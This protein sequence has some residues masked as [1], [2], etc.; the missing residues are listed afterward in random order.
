VTYTVE[1]ELPLTVEVIDAGR[2]TR[3][4]PW[5]APEPGWVE[6]RVS[7]G[8]LDITAALP[9]D[10]L[11]GLEGDARERLEAAAAEP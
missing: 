8:A 7:L 3:G 2:G 4:G 9:R 5:E 10:V 11:E 6:L 1:L